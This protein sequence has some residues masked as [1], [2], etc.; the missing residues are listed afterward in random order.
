MGVRE[1]GGWR[2]RVEGLV[3]IV[4]REQGDLFGW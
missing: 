4:G 2:L 3:L 1:V